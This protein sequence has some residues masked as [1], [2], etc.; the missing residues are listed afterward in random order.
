[1]TG[2]DAAGIWAKLSARYPRSL[3]VLEDHLEF[4][5]RTS[6]TKEGLDALEAAA[7]HA[8]S[9]H[10]ENLTERLS[11]ESLDRGDLA[12]GKRALA[13]LLSLTLPDERRVTTAGLLARVSLKEGG[14]FDALALGKTEAAKVREELRPDLWAAIA[15]AARDESKPALAV[16]LLVES[17]NLRLDR[18]R[19]EEAARLAVSAGTAPHLLR[20]F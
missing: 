19:L 3:G 18:M 5:F 6:R 2:G 8:A 4:L 14:A 17:L 13:T 7:S 10:R 12:R 16:D 9:G 11:K 20:F 15:E 1:A